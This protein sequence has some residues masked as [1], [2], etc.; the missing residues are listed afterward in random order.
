MI[1]SRV[2]EEENSNFSHHYGD[3]CLV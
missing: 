1:T 2:T 3:Q